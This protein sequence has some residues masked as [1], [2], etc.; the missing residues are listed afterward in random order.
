MKPQRSIQQTH[1]TSLLRRGSIPAFL[2]LALVLAFTTLSAS[3]GT[4]KRITIDGSFA[5]W[6]GVPVTSTDVE[7]DSLNGFDLKEIYVANDADNIYFM[8]KIYPS[9]T[10]TSLGSS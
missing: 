1:P 4:W 6:A 5:D 9:S 8:V 3:A 7:G 10:N 2:W